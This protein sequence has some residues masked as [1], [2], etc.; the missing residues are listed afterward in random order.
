MGKLVKICSCFILFSF[1]AFNVNISLAEGELENQKLLYIF[2]TTCG[3]CLEVS[4]YIGEI[5][6]INTLLLIIILALKKVK[7]YLMLIVV[8]IMLIMIIDM[9]Q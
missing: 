4:N 7:K 9:F 3:S 6:K 5:A 1:I 8:I 2:S